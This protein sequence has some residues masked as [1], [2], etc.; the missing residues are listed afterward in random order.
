MTTPEGNLGGRCRWAHRTG[1]GAKSDEEGSENLPLLHGALICVYNGVVRRKCQYT[2]LKRHFLHRG[3]YPA[4]R[5]WTCSAQVTFRGNGPDSC[6]NL[7][8]CWVGNVPMT[9][10]NLEKDK[11]HME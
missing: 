2:T 11:I 10:Y 3:D 5:F 9:Y 1:G 4:G 7:A 6:S 8:Y